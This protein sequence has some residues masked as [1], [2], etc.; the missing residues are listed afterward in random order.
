MICSRN[1]QK[2]FCKL[3]YEY[4][5]IRKQMIIDEHA[6]IDVVKD[7]KVFLKNIEELKPYLMECDK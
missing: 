6:P 3:G 7:S 1:F 5:D 2:W 4:K